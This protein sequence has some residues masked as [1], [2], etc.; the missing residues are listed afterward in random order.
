MGTHTNILVLSGGGVKGYS[1][2]QVLKLRE[3]EDGPLYKQY[4]LICSNSVGSINSSIIATGLV[5]MNELDNYWPEMAKFV[6]TKKKWYD[7]RKLPIYNRENF[8][9]IWDKL[10]GLD[11]KMKDVKTNLMILSVDYVSNTNRF[12]KSW[13]KDDGEE[14]LADVIARSF[15]APIYFGQYV[16]YI[17][18]KCWGDGGIGYYNFPLDEAKITAE[19]SGWYQNDNTILIDAIGSLYYERKNTFDRQRKRTNVGQLLDYSNPLGG[20]FARVQ[21]RSDQIRRMQYLTNKIPNIKFRY[22]DMECSK[23]IDKLDK[24][25]YLDQYRV[26]GIAMSKA[27]KLKINII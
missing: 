17:R 20:G 16:D 2:V 4:K 15:A 7:P 13:H 19:V 11:F 12:F 21:S 23:Q 6:F 27:P 14:R 9:T 8:Y 10:I 25:E 5:G 18:M 3:L 1:Q 22:W 26:L 24:I